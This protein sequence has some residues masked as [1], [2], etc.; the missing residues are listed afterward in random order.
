MAGGRCGGVSVRRHQGCPIHSEFHN[1]ATAGHSQAHHR[2]T[3]TTTGLRR[4]KTPHSCEV[5]S[6]RNSPVSTHVRGGEG[7]LSA[8]EET[9]LQPVTT[10]QWSR[11]GPATLSWVGICSRPR[12]THRSFRVKDKVRPVG[13]TWRSNRRL[14]TR[15]AE[16][17][18]WHATPEAAGQQIPSKLAPSDA[19]HRLW[20]CVKEPTNHLHRPQAPGDTL[21]LNPGDLQV[22]DETV[23]CR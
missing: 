13:T 8:G 12:S 3:A 19:Q 23:S 22:T 15:L 2:G 10:P 21:T 9:P 14:R 18:W 1:D 7:A 4:G 20:L 5:K 6:V 17:G 11:Y 16:R